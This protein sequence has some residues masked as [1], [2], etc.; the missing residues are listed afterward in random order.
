MK[1]LPWI[2]ILIGVVVVINEFTYIGKSDLAWVLIG[3]A[4]SVILVAVTQLSG[5]KG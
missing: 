1:Y 3:L 5:K 4:A 2:S